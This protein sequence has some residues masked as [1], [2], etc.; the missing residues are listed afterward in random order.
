MGVFTSLRARIGYRRSDPAQMDMQRGLRLLETVKGLRITIVH[1]TCSGS[2]P[3][4]QMPAGVSL[5]VTGVMFDTPEAS[6]D[7]VTI[8]LATDE[9][10]PSN[11]L[12][13]TLSELIE[14]T[15]ISELCDLADT[16]T[17]VRDEVPSTLTA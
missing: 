9:D 12:T 14:V 13:L 1:D 10:D 6:P 4:E 3:Y 2:L 16:V 17:A 8:F 15:N 5:L 11:D 7:E